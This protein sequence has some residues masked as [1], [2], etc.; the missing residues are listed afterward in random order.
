VTALVDVSIYQPGGTTLIAALDKRQGNTWMVEVNTPGTGQFVIHLDDPVLAAHPTMLADGNVVVVTR[1]ADGYVEKKWKIEARTPV[2]IGPGEK[3]GRLVTV[4]GRGLDAGAEKAVVWPYAMEQP[5]AS[6]VRIFGF[7]SPE[8]LSASGDTSTWTVPLGVRQDADPNRGGFPKPWVDGA[9][10]WIAPTD[11]TLAA[12][13]GRFY[14]RDE[15]TLASAAEV[16][17]EASF[18][19]FGELWL[20]GERI[21][22]GDPTDPY[23]WKQSYPFSRTEAA[24]THVIAGFVDNS[25]LHAGTNNPT[26][27]IYTVYTLDSAGNRD[28]NVLRSNTSTARVTTGAPGWTMGALL[29]QLF[30]EAQARG[31]T[32]LQ[33]FTFGFTKDLDSNG[34][35]WD[36]T[37]ELP[38]TIGDDL[39]K[40]LDQAT[41]LVCDIWADGYVLQAAPRRGTDRTAT[42]EFAAGDNIIVSAPTFRAGGKVNAALIHYNGRWLE[43]TDPATIGDYRAEV[44]LQL[45]NVESSTQAI[46][47][48]L[49]SFVETATPEI[50]IPIQISSVKGPLLG[51]DFFVADTVIGPGID[52]TPDPLRVMSATGSENEGEIGYDLACYPEG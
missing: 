30:T 25:G 40:I 33:H 50:T 7:A 24:G 28:T 21:I 51:V 14:F 18:D 48:A 44:F 37:D 32:L 31:V 4:S 35:P 47:M 23:N 11:P 52:E 42:V 2:P 43:V 45:G 3:A 1:V 19:N 9:A 12:P 16:L 34:D 29:I 27:V 38:L 26:G 39:G 36:V 13:I 8:A 6:D 15:F 20:D 5:T 46:K 41:E 22:I 49:A 10:K 17:L